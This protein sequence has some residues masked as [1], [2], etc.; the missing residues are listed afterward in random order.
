MNKIRDVER[1]NLAELESGV[2]LQGSW[3]WAYRASNY[4]FVGGL[5]YDLTEG[6][7][8]VKS[9]EQERVVVAEEK[10]EKVVMSQFGIITDLRLQRD[11]ETEKSKGFGWVSYGDWRSTVLA[12]DNMNGVELLGRKIGVDHALNYTPPDPKEGETWW[13]QKQKAARK[14][15]KKEKKKRKEKKEKK[16]RKDEGMLDL[17]GG[18]MKKTDKL[19][20]TEDGAIGIV[21][22]E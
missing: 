4:V 17:G 21:K 1:L 15:E 3:H 10:T 5:P 20:K 9:F 13:Q 18:L 19:I 2:S 16:K 8:E 11:P 14:K 7:L 6:D 12:V 22:R